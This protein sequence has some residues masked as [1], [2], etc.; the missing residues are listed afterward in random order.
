MHSDSLTASEFSRWLLGGLLLAFSVVWF[1]G[2]E[3]RK[4]TDPDEGRYAEISREMAL[5][6]DWVTPRLND[7]KYFEKPP[8]QYWVTAAAFRLFGEHHWVARWWPAV[9]TLG[10]VLLMFWVGRRL[11]DAEIGLMAAIIL[12]SCTGFIINAHILT[13][14]AGVASFLALALLSF[15]VAQC[16]NATPRENRNGMLVVWAAMGLAVLSKGLIGIVFPGAALV[17]YV[18]I[19]RDWV[20][21]SRLHFGKGLLLFLL[22]TAPWFI[23][24]S[25][26]NHEFT[27]FFFVHEHLQRFL[28]NVHNRKGAWW[29]FVPILLFGAMPWTPF[30]VL[31][32][33]Q[34]WRREGLRGT[35]QSQ[36]LLL[37]WSSFIFLFFSASHSKL[38]SY[39]LPVFP[40]L[41]LFAAVEMQ[42][43]TPKTLARCAWGLTV[44]GAVL[45]LVILVDGA[46]IT[47]LFSKASSPSE[48]V[49]HAIPWVEVSI[50]SFTI[51]AAVAAWLFHRHL[52]SVGI[53]ALAVGSLGA[54]TLALHGYDALSPLSSS[55]AIIHEIEVKQGLLDRS[56]PFYSV[57]MYD[58]TLPFYLKRPITLVQYID[59][60]ALGLEAEPFKGIQRVKDWKKRWRSLDQ[61]YAILSPEN[62]RQIAA[63]S[64][65]MRVLAR[66]PHRVIVSRQ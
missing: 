64:L 49:R 27:H 41:A 50:F 20:L 4:L 11:F 53:L 51:G 10:C 61:G 55:Y 8:L 52:R 23:V 17:I 66:D 18:L 12:G 30:I 29:Y 60:F 45:L 54:G 24:V 2:L 32:L 58:Q 22:L 5:S 15:L 40:A 21:L 43:I 26:R 59:E 56:L 13:L 31:R 36:R 28:S 14:D 6:G 47:R 63:E 7:L 42:R 38:P 37:I 25:L 57:Q 1:S 34:G 19:E 3:D 33:H 62:Y 16:P 44:S 35:L 46:H 48:I 9:T 65:P 39:I